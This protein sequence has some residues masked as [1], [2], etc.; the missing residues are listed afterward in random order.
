MSDVHGAGYGAMHNWS[1]IHT[2][3]WKTMGGK[4]WSFYTC[5]DCGQ[6]FV[7]YYHILKD[8][9]QAIK[10]SGVTEECKK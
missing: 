4:A 6:R 3:P 2:Y 5:K 8:I 7:H 9:F 10:D 1:R